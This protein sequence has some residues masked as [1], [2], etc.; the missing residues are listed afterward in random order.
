MALRHDF[1][2][3][4]SPDR[5]LAPEIR[6]VTGDLAARDAWDD[7]GVTT[8]PIEAGQLIGTAGGGFDFS[9]HDTKEYLSFVVPEHYFEESFKMYTVDP[10]DYFAEPVRSQLLEKNVRKVEPFGGKIDYDIDGR[11]VQVGVNN[12]TVHATSTFP[13]KFHLNGFAMVRL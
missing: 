1:L 7:G 4:Y 13:W 6:A 12:P 11:L 2:Y 8:I 5:P 3:I 9:V 10:Y